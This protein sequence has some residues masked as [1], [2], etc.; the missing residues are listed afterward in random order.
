MGASPEG[1]LQVEGFARHGWCVF[2][3]G[4]ACGWR[5]CT[6]A[7]RRV[8]ARVIQPQ[9]MHANESRSWISRGRS[10][11]AGCSLAGP[12]I[13]R[14]QR[15]QESP[16]S[17]VPGRYRWCGATAERGQGVQG[18]ASRLHPRAGRL[19][20]C[21]LQGCGLNSSHSQLTTVR[22]WG[23]GHQTISNPTASPVSTDV[24]RFS[25]FTPASRASRFNGARLAGLTT[26]APSSA[27]R[28]TSEPAP[29]PICSTTSR[30]LRTP[31]LSP[32]C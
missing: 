28:L 30:R 14:M 19:P 3:T 24:W 27:L 18:G 22:A 10:R 13:L 26:I 12:A 7:P 1:P 4:E 23:T 8:S 9:G 2:G 20:A 25:A 21:A 11:S 16:S 15:S 29:R 31:R 5:P 32:R 17:G 6:G